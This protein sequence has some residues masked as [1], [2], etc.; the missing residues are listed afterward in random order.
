MKARILVFVLVIGIGAVAVGWVYESQLRE[1]VQQTELVIPAN[2][3]YFLTD[4][5]Y[6]SINETG[7]LDYEF[8]SRRLEHYPRDDISKIENPSLKIYRADDPWRVDAGRGEFVHAQ[9]L[10][11]L[12]Q[13][14]VMQKGGNNPLRITSE[15]IRFEPDRDR[16]STD[17]GIVMHSPRAQIEADSAEF[18][19]TNN[20]YRLSRTRAIY[21]HGKS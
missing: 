19:L 10:L 14:V 18:D 17:S 15:E 21:R 5:N 12:Q 11:R 1:R 7:N 13:Q 4:L 9:N 6:R 8:D 3:D 20:V 2:I 16:V